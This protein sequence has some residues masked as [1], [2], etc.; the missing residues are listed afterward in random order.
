MIIILQ[1]QGMLEV[2]Q[3]EQKTSNTQVRRGGG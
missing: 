2:I 1:S 3:Q